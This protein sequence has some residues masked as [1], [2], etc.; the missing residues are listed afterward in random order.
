MQGADGCRDGT[1]TS[2][3]YAAVIWSPVGGHVSTG[4]TPPL[5]PPAS[6]SRGEP[7][8]PYL[9]SPVTRLVH[10]P[11]NA[12]PLPQP[13]ARP[14]SS[15]GHSPP[16]R[17]H[18]PAY[19]GHSPTLPA[20]PRRRRG[21]PRHE[22][23]TAPL[24][25]GDAPRSGDSL[26]SRDGAAQPPRDG[27]PMPHVHA[28]PAPGPVHWSLVILIRMP[29]WTQLGHAPVRRCF[30]MWRRLQQPRERAPPAAL[31]DVLGGPRDEFPSRSTAARWNSCWEAPVSVPGQALPAGAPWPRVP[32][33]SRVGYRR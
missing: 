5:L 11:P 7:A 19:P 10:L 16:C 8:A 23:D 4:G 33:P 21:R 27:A 1:G 12:E 14:R 20:P 15:H 32:V 9:S 25:R 2:R 18:P 17:E 3:T 28:Q 13:S 22:R 31:Q 29:W 26:P 30:D 6:R 24:G